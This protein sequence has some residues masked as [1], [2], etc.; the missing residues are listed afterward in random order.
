MCINM[1]IN[2]AII[3]INILILIIILMCSN[4]IMCINIINVYVCVMK[5]TSNV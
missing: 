1:C 3:N 4:N 2:I 5:M